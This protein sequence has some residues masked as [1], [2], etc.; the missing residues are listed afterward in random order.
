[1]CTSHFNIFNDGENS[2]FTPGT[3]LANI[4]RVKPD[5]PAIIYI[6]SKDKETIMTWRA[7]EV[8]S[9]RIAWYLLEK[10]IGPGK[11]VIAVLGVEEF[12]GKGYLESGRMLRSRIRQGSQAEPLR[13]L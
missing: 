2:F 6:P 5:A 4:A 13:D 9:N 8:L 3:Q 7:L 11:S 10:G 1:M 12:A